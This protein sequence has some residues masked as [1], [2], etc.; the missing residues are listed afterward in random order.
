MGQA[1]GLRRPLRPPL[2][3]PEWIGY[4]VTQPQSYKERVPTES[5][6]RRLEPARLL[7]GTLGARV[8]QIRHRRLMLE[9]RGQAVAV[10]RSTTLNRPTPSEAPRRPARSGPSSRGELYA[11]HKRMGMVAVYF[12]FFPGP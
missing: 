6:T 8:S 11:Y 9:F 1:L 2:P 4:F 12:S 3:L 5:Q 10:T 7:E